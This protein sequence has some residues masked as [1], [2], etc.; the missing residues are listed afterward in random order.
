MYH[1]DKI[2]PEAY[3][4]H[5]H[6]YG[7]FTLKVSACFKSLYLVFVIP[8]FVVISLKETTVL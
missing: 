6:L 8:L 7:K 1:R 2:K 3:C 4:E 5:V